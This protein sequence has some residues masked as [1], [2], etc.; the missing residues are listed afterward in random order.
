MLYERFFFWGGGRYLLVIYSP[1]LLQYGGNK[2]AL[3]FLSSQG[4]Y[5]HSA[6]L[7]QKYN[8][9]SAALYKDKVGG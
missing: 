5:D 8:S 1:T 4:D 3:E 9:R 2:R 6:P 7:Q